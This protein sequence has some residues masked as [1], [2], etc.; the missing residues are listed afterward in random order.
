VSENL[1]ILINGEPFSFFHSGRGLCQCFLLSPLLFVLAMEALTLLNIGQ[2]DGKIS[3]IKVSRTIKILHLLF[4]NDVLVMSNDSLHDWSEI[5]KILNI[6]CCA[7]SLLIN[8]DKST[9]HFA[10]IHQHILD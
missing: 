6:F 9:F 10:N 8:W 3:V 2:A 1:A 7:T 5:K 4:V